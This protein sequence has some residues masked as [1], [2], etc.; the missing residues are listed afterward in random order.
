MSNPAGACV[1]CGGPRLTKGHVWPLWLGK[2]L[3]SA[4][5]H[6][7]EV[8]RF[9]TFTPTIPGPE[10]SIEQRQGSAR[11]R[12]PRNTCMTCNR[13]WMSTIE[14]AA[15]KPMTPLILGIDV[16]LRMED[17][18]AIAA[19]LCLI[20]M[21]L[22]FL[23]DFRAIPPS[24]R[25]ELKRTGLPPTGWCIWLARFIGKNGEDLVSN[26]CGMMAGELSPPEHVGPEHCNT[27]A[28]TLVIGKLCA[29]LFRSS[30]VPFID[31]REARLTRIWPVTGFDIQTEFMPTISD[32]GIL[33]LAEAIAREALGPPVTS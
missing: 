20:N 18:R 8:G 27:Q 28:T 17:Q 15:I 30:F 9:R 33:S 21:R 25:S 3:P 31:Y 10:H 7:M 6:E 14:S 26:Y 19:L 2:I 16:P 29:H 11:S 1:F 23:G 22:E 5:H 32:D 12:K 4:T 24:D 13:G